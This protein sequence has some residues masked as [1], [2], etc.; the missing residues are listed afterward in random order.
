MPPAL[1]ALARAG[2]SGPDV[3]ISLRLQ[4]G[5]PHHPA[6]LSFDKSRQQIRQGDVLRLHGVAAGGELEPGFG[7]LA[8]PG[9]DVGERLEGVKCLQRR[10]VH[11]ERDCD[12]IRPADAVEV[13]LDVAEHEG[14]L[15]E[16]AQVVDDLQP[17]GGA[18]ARA[19]C[20]RVAAKNAPIAASAARSMFRRCMSAS[21]Q[22]AN[23]VTCV[24]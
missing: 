2:K 8:D 19:A 9:A 4:L 23:A 21:L 14:G 12:V 1:A 13:I 16:V 5:D 6:F 17:V 24:Q 15:V 7:E 20:A 11:H 3:Q 10:A 22:N 18:G